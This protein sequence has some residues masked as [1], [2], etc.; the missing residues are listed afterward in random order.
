MNK[1][2]TQQDHEYMALAISLA[3][4]GRFTTTPNPNVGC[5][6]VKDNQIVGQG[7][8]Q[9]AGL[10][11]AEVNALAQA[12]E[13]ARGATAYVTL[14][15]CSH[16]GR[17]PPCAQALINAGVVKVISAMVDPNP[18][19]SGRGLNMLNEAGIK[20]AHGL[21]ASEAEKLNV[22][23]LKRMRK[24]M[25]F[26]SCKL[27]A[28]LDGKTAL[29]NGK[30]KWITSSPA[31]QDV[32][33]LRA[34]SCAVL[35]GADT[36]LCDDAKLNVRYNELSDA[37]FTESQLRQPIRIII[38]SQN[39]LTPELALFSISSPII[40]VRLHLDNRHKWPH[41]VEQICV[42]EHDGKVDLTALMIELAKRDI[43]HLFLECG[44]TLAGKMSELNLI[45]QYIFYLAPKL[46]GGAA[47]SLL[48]LP[49]F[50]KMDEVEQLSIEDMTMVGHDIRIIANKAK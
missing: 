28:S 24:N 8:H 11:H 33:R 36:V 2:F 14:E 25:P 9:K 46:M 23:F 22:G 19:V 32:Q 49:E 16:T 43:N 4:K 26:V 41:F 47:K 1:V 50:Q 5:V 15:P 7:F 3:K 17:T 27:A 42:A 40:I 35:S 45:D 44:A 31:R 10:G 29:A 39:R 12:G 20:T 48:A 38:D 30:S 6:L 21:L 18:K 13:M 34:L 37:P